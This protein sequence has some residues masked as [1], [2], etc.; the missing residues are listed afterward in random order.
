MTIAKLHDKAR[1]AVQAGEQKFREAA[2]CLAAAKKLGATQ[3]QSAKAIN[4]SPSWVN[5]LLAWRK[6]GYK[7]GAFER[8][9]KNRAFSRT[10]QQRRPMTTEEAL[11][12]MAQ[13]EFQK[14][15][16]VAV[17]AMFGAETK[18]IPAAA[19]KELL[20]ALAMLASSRDTA[21]V[22]IERQRARLNLTWDDLLVAAEHENESPLRVATA[23]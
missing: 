22:L 6:S 16:A 9:N 19:R 2:E 11:A 12:Q 7:G 21:A 20:K 17:A 13:A 10:K 14:A 3:R 5:Q 1:R 8:S 18:R 4:K 23:A 15:R